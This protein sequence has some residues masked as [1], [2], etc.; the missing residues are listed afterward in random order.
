IALQDVDLMEVARGSK[1]VLTMCNLAPLSSM[2]SSSSVTIK[3]PTELPAFPPFCKW[4]S[5]IFSNWH[6]STLKTEHVI[7]PK[8]ELQHEVPL[9]AG[10][11]INSDFWALSS[12][13]MLRE[14]MV[15]QN[16]VEASI[17]PRR[18]VLLHLPA[19]DPSIR[20]SGLVI[21]D[22]VFWIVVCNSRVF[23]VDQ[24]EYGSSAFLAGQFTLPSPH[25]MAVVRH[26]GSQN[27]MIWAVDAGG[28]LFEFPPS[29]LSPPHPSQ[30]KYAF[31]ATF[32]S[33]VQI[34]SHFV[35]GVMQSS[36]QAQPDP[37]SYLTL[38][39]ISHMA[40]ATHHRLSAYVDH[41]SFSLSPSTCSAGQPLAFALAQNSIFALH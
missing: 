38:I 2:S 5:M 1:I 7:L 33:I 26:H 18:T 32:S 29:Q 39:P 22:S 4:A 14:W 12:D 21:S 25:A 20:A 28:D 24:G 3:A 30:M 35:V 17:S 36:E 13:G 37:S 23:V 41:I 34:D 40:S 9:M 11:S 27:P 15:S 16:L 8:A 10:V 31:P 19:C 6:L